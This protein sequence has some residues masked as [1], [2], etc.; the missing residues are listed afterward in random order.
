M[1]LLTRRGR[2]PGSRKYHPDD[3]IRRAVHL[4]VHRHRQ[5][6]L[7]EWLA[8]QDERGLATSLVDLMERA[9]SGGTVGRV[10][11]GEVETVQVFE[12]DMSG[13]MEWD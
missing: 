2:P 4:T 3:V 13:L 8:A 7:A 6:L 10:S 5:P 11:G 1:Q 12:V 9:L